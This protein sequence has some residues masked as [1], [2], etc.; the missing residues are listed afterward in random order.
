MSLKVLL[1]LTCMWLKTQN[2]V[3]QISDLR[4]TENTNDNLGN[5]IQFL[6]DFDREAAEMCNRV[7]SSEWRYAINATDFNK[8]RMREQQNLVSKFECLSWRRAASFDSST[9]VDSS[10]RRQLGR[11]VQPGRCGLGEDKYAEITHVI[12]LMKDN[13]NNAKVCPFPGGKSTV[14]GSESY[15]SSSYV[16]TYTT[17]CDLKLEPELVRIM[18][19]SRAEPELRYYWLAWREKTGPSVKNTFM[20]YL[21]LANQAAERHGFNDAGDQMR[22]LY[23]DSEF[24]FSVNDLWMKIQPLYKQLVTFVRK[25]LV[26]HYGEQVVRKDGPLPAH[27]LGNMWAQNW[28]SILSLIQPGPSEMPDITGEMVRQGYT[29]F[30]M[31]QTAEEFFTSIGLPPMAPEFWRNSVF[32]K[33]NE[34]Y[35]QC[36]ASAWDFCNKIDFRIKQCT[37][38]SLE[39]FVNA[40]HEMTHVQYYMQYASQPFLYREGPNPAFHEALANAISLCVGGPTHLQKLGLLNT[41]V[42]VTNGNTMIN[43]EY[44]LSIALDKLPFMAYSLAL[45]K[46]RWYVFEKGPVGMNARWWELRL[47]YQGIIPPTGRGFEHF[48][49]GAKYHVISDQDYIK[50]FVATVLQFQIYSEL[51]LASHHVGPLHTCDFYRSREAGRILSDV[52]QQGAALS[53]SQLLKLLTRGKTSRLSA[54]PLIDFFRPLEAWLELQNKDEPIIGWSSRMEDFALFQPLV[55]R[56]GRNSAAKHMFSLLALLMVCFYSVLSF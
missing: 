2:V 33:S 14:P 3:S 21:D 49:A 25:G 10:I 36:T 30:K 52:M 54:E 38:V 24:F 17:Y 32:Q 37:Q 1:I 20:R 16:A 35:G 40:H 6:R 12:S 4:Y 53:S 48:D 31:F 23:D 26:R 29:P 8:R 18:E 9:I 15:R 34:M 46:W 27:I 28:H 56:N 45:E 5:A 19:S 44:L 51:C 55:D 11:I 50:Y 47:R 22:S 7:A 39:D 43:I 41:P 13:Y 42:S